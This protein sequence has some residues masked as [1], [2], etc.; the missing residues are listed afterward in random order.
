MIRRC[1]L[2]AADRT[3]FARKVR[4]FGR[5]RSC[6]FWGLWS[7]AC[8]VRMDARLTPL[9]WAGGHQ[10]NI[11]YIIHFIFIAQFY[12]DIIHVTET[13]VIAVYGI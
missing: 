7:G 4:C 3:G 5:F 10:L 13:S 2:Y 1:R 8:G 11:R 9:E 6:V 12:V